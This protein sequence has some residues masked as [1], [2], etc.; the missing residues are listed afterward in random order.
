MPHGHGGK[1][2]GAGRPRESINKFSAEVRDAAVASGEELPLQYMLRIMNDPQADPHRRDFMAKAAAAYVHP[3]L[4][5][6]EV[7]GKEGSPVII[8]I[9]PD[10]AK[11]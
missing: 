6:T 4:N 1:R 8:E 5:S 2:A 9:T 10:E 11:Y 7:G 3:R